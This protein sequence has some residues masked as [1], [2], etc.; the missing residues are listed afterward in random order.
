MNKYKIEIWRYHGIVDEF[1]S[2]DILSVRDWWFD[3]WQH[4]YD[5]GECSFYVYENNRKMSFD[6][7]YDPGFYDDD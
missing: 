6:E 5:T 7:L 4:A 1:S 2:D 3:G